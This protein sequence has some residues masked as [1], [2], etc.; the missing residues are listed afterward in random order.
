MSNYR[1]KLTKVNTFIFDYD[2]VFS[3]GIV[4]L[5]PEGE[6]L[7]TANVKDGY[8]LQL[9]R[10]NN[11]NIAVISGGNSMSIVKRFEALQLEDI[12]LKVEKKI[13]VYNDYLKKKN[14]THENVL[15]MGDDIPD[16]EIMKVAGVATCPADAAVEIRE[17]AMYISHLVGGKGCVRD[18]VEQVLKLQGKWMNGDAFNW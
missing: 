2:G 17:I 18:V 5:T 12:F 16:L 4:Y 9:A 15:F 3:D 11:Y 8:A 13:D 6:A 14:I 10:K 1:E 7:R